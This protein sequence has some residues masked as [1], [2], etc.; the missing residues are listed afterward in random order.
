MKIQESQHN[1]MAIPSLPE[2]A[3]TLEE[4]VIPKLPTGALSKEFLDKM[5]KESGAPKFLRST[6]YA[7]KKPE[8][9][10]KIIRKYYPEAIPFGN[11]NFIFL[12][13][14][15]KQPVLFNPEGLDIGDLAEYARIGAEILGAIGGGLAGGLV[16][17]P[18]VAGIPAGVLGGSVVGSV[19]AGEAFDQIMRSF[20]GK[21]TEDTRTVGEHLGDVGIQ[22]AVETIAPPGIS[23][24]GGFLRKNANKLFNDPNAKAIINSAE[25]LNIKD[26]PLGV[27]TGPTIAKT[28]N[29]LASSLGGSAISKS[30][31]AS[32]DQLNK[33]IFDLTEEGHD[34]AKNQAGDIIITGAKRFED[35]FITES[36]A[37]YKALN[38]RIPTTTTFNLPATQNVLASLQTKFTDPKLGKEFGSAMAAKLKKAMGQEPKLTYQDMTALRSEIGG[39]L[40]GNFV[41]GTSPNIADLK[42]IYG[43]LSDDMVAAADSLGGDVAALSSFTNTYYKTGKDF[44][45]KQINPLITRSGKEFLPPEIAYDKVMNGLQRTPSQTNQFLAKIFNTQ[46][47]NENQLKLLGEKQ[48]FDLTRNVDDFYGPAQTIKNL[49]KLQKG[50]GQ[51]PITIQKLG[52][53]VDDI[54]TI[55]EGFK[56]AGKSVNFSNTAYSNAHNQLYG[57]LGI[58][59][60]ILTGDITTGL[61]IAGASYL[62]PKGF[63]FLLTNP[64]TKASFKNWATKADLPID[65]KI[66]VLTGIGFSAP[67]AQRFINSAYVD[68]SLLPPAVPQQ[69][70][71]PEALIPTQ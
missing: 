21:G 54:K 69:D 33:A 30:Y 18:T 35:N 20:Y 49:N 28:E 65:A 23:K 27:M 11:N 36:D 22:A 12:N 39:M 58:G 43:A 38:D 15:T 48:F 47:G 63:T 55:S 17:S 32:M 2:N 57:A 34:L 52:S 26:L 67:Q 8:D 62:T 31:L 6:V 46:L 40:K 10:L 42:R 37:L 29:A 4:P 13:P 16:T 5:D 1:K 53:S 24:A 45:D 25:N 61:S 9:K 44:I 50:T 14:T 68:Q 71:T 3:Y 59:S 41:I 60:G 66:S 70:T 64:A 7:Y 19:S 56:E 51:L